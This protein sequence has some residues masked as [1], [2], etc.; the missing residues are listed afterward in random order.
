[1][2]SGVRTHPIPEGAYPVPYESVQHMLKVADVYEG[3]WIVTDAGVHASPFAARVRANG[4]PATAHLNLV[5]LRSPHFPDAY[6]I[7]ED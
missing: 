7:P 5:Y 4:Y 2:T 3:E 1:M 6:S